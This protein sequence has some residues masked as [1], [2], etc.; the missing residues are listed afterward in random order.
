[1]HLLWRVI[2]SSLFVII[3]SLQQAEAEWGA[4]MQQH[5]ASAGAKAARELH[6]QEL[7]AAQ[8]RA[9]REE[10]DRKLAEELQRNG[11]P[12]KPKKTSK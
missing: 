9:A 5:E 3:R 10:A 4:A 8:Q 7:H 6:A 11:T 2:L 12:A 1:M